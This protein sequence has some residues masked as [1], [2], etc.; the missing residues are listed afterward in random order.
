MKI[1]VILDIFRIS[2]TTPVLIDSLYIVVKGGERIEDAILTIVFGT[3][4][5]VLLPSSPLKRHC[6]W[7][8]VTLVMTKLDTGE[9]CIYL[10]GSSFDFGNEFAKL[11]PTVTKC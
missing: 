8:S 11:G 9:L 5:E 4:I 10:H 3:L 1:G 7:Y 6:T 2:G